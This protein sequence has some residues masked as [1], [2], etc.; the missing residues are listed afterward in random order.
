MV[1]WI[2]STHIVYS[3]TLV[4]AV[5]PI[6]SVLTDATTVGAGSSIFALAHTEFDLI[7]HKSDV[8]TVVMGKISRLPYHLDSATITTEVSREG[9]FLGLVCI[10]IATTWEPAFFVRASV[11][12]I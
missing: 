5:G 12:R 2:L 8:G 6:V 9:E 3:F 7:S 11:P 1:V 10:G 4:L